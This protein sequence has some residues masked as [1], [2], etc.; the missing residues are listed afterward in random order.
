MAETGRLVEEQAALRRVATLVAQGASQ[1]ELFAVVAEQVA[2]VLPVPFL[3]IVR[4][5]S[6]GTATERAHY[7]A[8]GAVFEVGTHWTLDGPSVVTMVLESGRPARIDDY[9]GI[10]GQIADAIRAVGITS[11]VGIPIV[12]A[13]RL[14]GTMVVSSDRPEPLPADT[15][16]HL[17]DFTELVATAIANSE[18]QAELDRLASEQAALRRVATLVAEERTPDEMFAQVLEEVG[19]LLGDADSALMRFERDGSATVLA[20]RSQADPPDGVRPGI[21]IPLGGANV[22]SMVHTSGRTA[23]IDDYATSSGEM[24]RRVSKHLIRSAVGVPIAVHGRLWGTLIVAGRDPGAMPRDTEARVAEF[25]ELLGTA[26]ANADARAEVARLADEQ[27]ALRRV[28]THVAQ[29]AA[30]T[31][32]FAAAAVVVAQLLEADLVALGR[33]E[34]DTITIVA[35]H[36][37]PSDR[38]PV[39]V[40]MRLD[41]ENV[42]GTVKR[43]G[44]SAR[45]DDLEHVAGAIGDVVHRARLTASVGAPVIVD[46]NVWGVIITSWTSGT[47][48]PPDTEARLAQFAELLSTAIANADSRA[49]LLASRLRM[50]AAEDDARRRV[51]RD[52]HDG[53]QQRLVQGILVL[54]LAQQALENGDQPVDA[55]VAEAL[56]SVERGH[57]ELR[58]L[59]H[60]ILPA[61]LADGGLR[62][63]VATFARRLPLPVTT[64]LTELRFAPQL[65]ASAY[66]VI[67]EA[68]TNLVKHAQASAAEVRVE[69]VDGHLNVEVRDDGIGG[70]DA[71]GHGLVGIDDRVILLGGSL[72]VESPPAGGTIVT[73]TIP[74]VD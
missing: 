65:E 67:A 61:V 56:E 14:W 50:L 15:E 2:A 54:R 63:G 48:P 55:L 10:A 73:A 39:G 6:D 33:F 32:V 60:G 23:R 7:A 25:T 70:A 31:D 22:T 17:T 47:A 26:I 49:Q 20:V 51:V 45:L 16:S 21:R 37:D 57:E 69:L 9:E 59:A 8:G 62:A 42:A 1:P 11:T 3:S 64:E 5:E 68:L 74:V 36:G 46:G 18:A 28:A 34:K 38:V 43:T 29:G 35:V 19:T 4:F 30:P 41:G 27:A 71:N 24:G 40:P 52:L 53:A 12:V 58:E 13:G 72:H 44:R 66:L